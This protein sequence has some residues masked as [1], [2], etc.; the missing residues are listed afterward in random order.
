MFTD[1]EDYDNEF[2]KGL[3][4]MISNDVEPMMNVFAVEQDLF[5]I[6]KEINLIPNGS[7]VAVTNENKLKYIE[8]ISMFKMYTEVSEQTNAFLEGFYEIIPK[9]LA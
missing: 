4:W 5:G 3:E 6:M 1:L 9:D 7:T 2:Y 8:A